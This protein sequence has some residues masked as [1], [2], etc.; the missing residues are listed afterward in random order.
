MAILTVPG[1]SELRAFV[2]AYDLGDLGAFEGLE[3][4]TVNTSYRLQIGDRQWFLRIYEEQGPEGA[5]READLL[6]HLA[7]AGVPTPTPAVGRDGRRTRTIAG[8]PGAL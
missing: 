7:G 8:K 6:G 2:A 3:A 1:E 5:A 4:G